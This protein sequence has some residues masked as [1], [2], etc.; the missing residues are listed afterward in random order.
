LGGYVP[1]KKIGFETAPDKV[2]R[3]ILRSVRSI[4]LQGYTEIVVGSPVFTGRFRSN[5]QTSTIG[6]P[7]GQLITEVREPG[8]PLLASEQ[9][10]IEGTVEELGRGNATSVHITNNLPYAQLLEDGRSS[11]NQGFVERAV[12]NMESR[13]KVLA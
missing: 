12:R 11:Q 8:E 3:D 9:Q 10:K 4:V 5:W 13:L 7:Q 6:R 2:R 1:V